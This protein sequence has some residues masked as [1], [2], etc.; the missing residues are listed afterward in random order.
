M[1]KANEEEDHIDRISDLPS[2]VIDGI[3]ENLEIRDLVMTSILSTKWRYKWTYVPKLV[4]G[5]NF[6]EPYEHLDDPNPVF[7]KIVMD[8]LMLHNG[9]IYKFCLF[10]PAG[11][12]FKITVENFDTWVPLLSRRGIKNF[13]L[14][15]LET[16]LSHL[17]YVVFSSQNSGFEYFDFSAPTLKVLYLQFNQDVKSICLKKANN[18]IDLTLI[19][20]DDWLSGVV[21]S[22]PKNIQRF[23]IFSYFTKKIPYADIIAPTLVKSSFN[24]LKLDDVKLNERGELL[25]IVSVLKSA[26]RL[27]EL[28]VKHSFNHV[29]ITQVPH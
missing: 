26:P 20:D 10:I 27:V 29:D 17:P 19:S 25:Y 28:V 2:N 16:T 15:D 18:L 21:K 9:P 14:M 3:L 22:L 24:Y 23:S 4:F 11:F 12:N 7:S 6:F 5:M 1:K 8:V 13:E